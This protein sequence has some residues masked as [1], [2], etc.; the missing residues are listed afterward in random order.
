MPVTLEPANRLQNLSQTSS[1]AFCWSSLQLSLPSLGAS[2]CGQGL[3]S[4]RSLH[5][6][7]SPC[8]PFLS[9]VTGPLVA[10]D[11]VVGFF[12]FCCSLCPLAVLLARLNPLSSLHM[13]WTST[14]WPGTGSIPAPTARRHH[15]PLEHQLCPPWTPSLSVVPLPTTESVQPLLL[16]QACFSYLR[17]PPGSWTSQHCPLYPMAVWSLRCILTSTLS[18]Y[19]VLC[20]TAHVCPFSLEPG[21]PHSMQTLWECCGPCLGGSRCLLAEGQ[22]EWPKAWQT[23]VV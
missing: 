18:P 8:T 3:C 10:L 23:L 15:A 19:Q 9:S 21:P 1:S 6:E 20:A 12:L 2:S 14:P 5:Q 7:G 22:S 11:A 4:V 16:P 13:F 17:P